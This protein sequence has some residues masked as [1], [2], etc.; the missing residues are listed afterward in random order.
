MDE[1]LGQITTVARGMWIY[2]RLALALTWLV[3]LVGMGVVFMMPN[4]YQASARVFVDTQ[5]ILRPLMVGIAVQPNIEQQVAMLS[6]TLLSRPTV[7]RLVR[8]A[9]LDLGAQSKAEKD[10]VID[11]VTQSISIKTAGRDNIYTLSYSDTKPEVAQ[12]VVQALLTIFVES[13]LGASRQD[14]D[15]ARRFLDD[16]IK[17][18]ETKL[19]EAEGRLKEFKLRNIELQ[20][21]NG[22][23]SAGRAAEIGNLLSQA[24]LELRE[25]ESARA[26]AA[27]QLEALR[28]SAQSP[29]AAGVQVQTPEID[30]RLDVQRRNLDTLL[31]RYT[32][33]HP[34]VANARRLISE[35]EGEKRRE[36]EELQRRL[37]ANPDDPVLQSNPAVQEISRLL[38]TSEVQAASLR[39]RV[40]E[41]ESRASRAHEQLKVAPQLEAEFAQLNRDYEIHHKNYSDLVGRR[42]SALMS[43][44]LEN[45]SN[46]AEFRVIDPPRVGAKP[47]APNRMLLLPLS[48]LVALGAGLGLA[49]LM[50]Q[51]RPVF[52]DGAA[53]R[54]LTQMPLLGVVEL[55]PN[56]KLL[57][58][59]ARSFKRVL[60]ALFALVFLYAGGMAVLSYQSGALG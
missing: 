59:E 17:S 25:A 12:R 35:I 39:A 21:Q 24:R 28:A 41:Y 53:L 30:A 2:R 8:A 22:L 1:L 32:E 23:D 26:A 57:Q 42:E 29:L 43:G 45:T 50:S 36:I 55:V 52:F 54:Q 6:R 44:E 49:F 38:A 13:S 18:Y 20:S 47:V 31:Q 48:L 3:A 5:S 10:A 9:D 4:S 34:D 40:A 51:I 14:S 33:V 58:S 16:Q 7:E 46:V 37:K 19:T 27:R 15:S 11:K 56:E 60:A